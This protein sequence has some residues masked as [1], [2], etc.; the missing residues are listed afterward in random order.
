MARIGDMLAEG[1]EKAG[2]DRDEM[3]R[4]I[5]ISPAAVRA[6]EEEDWAVLPA[7]VFV[8]GFV[9][10]WCR[11][12]GMDERLARDALARSIDATDRP[13]DNLPRIPVTTGIVVGAGTGGRR[14]MK[15]RLVRGIALAAFIAAVIVIAVMLLR[16]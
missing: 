3:A 2:L 9:T 1:R 12:A 6:L 14:G 8:R 5:R 7:P 15:G 13:V 16:Y 10:S 4:T 11:A